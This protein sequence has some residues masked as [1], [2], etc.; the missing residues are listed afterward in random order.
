V[1]YLKARVESA[2]CVK[3]FIDSEDIGFSLARLKEI[4][5]QLPASFLLVVLYN[6]NGPKGRVKVVHEK[7]DGIEFL[8]GNLLKVLC[9]A[10]DALFVS[11]DLYRNL[12]KEALVDEVKDQCWIETRRLEYLFMDGGS[13]YLI[14]HDLL[15]KLSYIEK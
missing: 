6:E 5:S 4:R 1:T 15:M 13:T 14:H 11:N 12:P 9:E 7:F 8:K 3:V 2:R 10:E